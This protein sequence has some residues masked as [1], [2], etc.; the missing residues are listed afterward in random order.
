MYESGLISPVE[1]AFSAPLGVCGRTD[2]GSWVDRAEAVKLR[3]AI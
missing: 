1:Q 3:P 2:V